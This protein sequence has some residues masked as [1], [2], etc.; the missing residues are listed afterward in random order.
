MQRGQRRPCTILSDP[1]KPTK[2]GKGDTFDVS[3]LRY[4]LR[5]KPGRHYPL[6]N[7][8]LLST[9]QEFRGLLHLELQLLHIIAGCRAILINAL[10]GTRNFTMTVWKFSVRQQ[11]MCQRCLL[12]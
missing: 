8:T 2:V 10:S 3:L 5:G 12:G 1:G 11:E 6:Y 9:S 4:P 7:C